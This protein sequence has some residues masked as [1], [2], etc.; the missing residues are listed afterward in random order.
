MTKVD[1]GWAGGE[2][3]GGGIPYKVDINHNTAKGWGKE[4]SNEE[5]LL[6]RSKPPL[7]GLKKKLINKQ[8]LNGPLGFGLK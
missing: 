5:K 7:L 6:L 8:S 2:G 3:G 4:K 1:I